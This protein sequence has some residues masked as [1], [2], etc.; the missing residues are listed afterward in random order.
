MARCRNYPPGNGAW[1]NPT[2]SD[3]TKIDDLWHAAVNGRGDFF[4]ATDPA[5]FSNALSSSLSNIIARTGSASAVA[6]NSSSLRTDGRLY[7]AKFNSG[8]WSGELLS[9]PVDSHGNHGTAEWD[10][11]KV[12]LAPDVINPLTRV[13]IVKGNT[14]GVAFEYANLTA[15]QKASLDQDAAGNVDNC[16]L[17]RVAFLRGDASREGTGG[18]F[19][20]ASTTVVD[21]FH[22][23]TSSKL[24][25]IVNSSPFFVG[26]PNAG[27]S[28]VGPSWLCCI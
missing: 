21:K 25:D 17:E 11:G 28:D 24:G 6:A 10:A 22:S 27:Y 13:I 26:V 20:C 1:P 12:S 18:T 2:T 14:D 8:D 3:A 5:T 7:Q 23:R 19:I 9:I 4:S 16:G 15:A